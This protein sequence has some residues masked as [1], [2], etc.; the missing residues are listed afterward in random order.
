MVTHA[1]R[2]PTTRAV[3]RQ[4]SARVAA[5]TEHVGPWT[6]RQCQALAVVHVVALAVIVA[7][8]WVT[9]YEGYPADQ[10]TWLNLSVAAML[11][12]AGA[13]WLF[14]TRGHRLTSRVRARL[15]ITAPVARTQVT[16]ADE[17]VAV[18]GARRFHAEGC[19]FVAGKSVIGAARSLHVESWRVPCEVC[20]PGGEG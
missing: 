9:V 19:A 15:F 16:T 12:T 17:F 7:S 8:Y 14:F 11:G 4:I 13:D 10:L 1:E 2:Q 3:R 5:R 6:R 18:E 20:L